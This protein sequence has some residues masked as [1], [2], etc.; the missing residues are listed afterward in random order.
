MSKSKYDYIIDGNI[1]FIEDLNE[2]MSVTNDIENVIKEISNQEG[3]LIGRDVI[4]RDSENQIDG[5][6]LD[7]KGE[8][9]D[10]YFIGEQNYH[11]AKLK[12]I[13]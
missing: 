4:Y 9:K 3:S 8:F 2:G 13:K 12:I 10:F 11:A 7:N 1:I 5:I 6:R